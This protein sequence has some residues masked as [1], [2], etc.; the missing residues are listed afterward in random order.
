[1][2]GSTS[3]GTLTLD[4]TD[5][6]IAPD[7]NW[8]TWV[9][10]RTRGD[11]GNPTVTIKSN[12]DVR[13]SPTARE[14]IGDPES[15]IVKTLD[16]NDNVAIG[17]FAAQPGEQNITKLKKGGGINLSNLFRLFKILPDNPSAR[18]PVHNGDGFIYFTMPKTQE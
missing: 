8:K 1:M 12:G 18:F 17:F 3:G 4:D 13:L 6:L 15:V 9:N 2:W 7:A 16:M 10:T 5:T 14:L 11:D